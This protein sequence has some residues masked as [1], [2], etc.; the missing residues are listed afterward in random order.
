M[1]KKTTYFCVF[2]F[3]FLLSNYGLCQERKVKIIT[4]VET[5]KNSTGRSKMI[6][7]TSIRNSE[8]FTTTRTEGKDTKQKD[9]NRS[10]AKV[11]NLQETKL[12][13][14]VNAGGVQY[15]NVASNDAIVASRVAELLTE[16]WELKSVVSSM[17]NKSTSFQ[18][19]RYIFIQ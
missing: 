19:T 5:T 7:V 9:I 3:L 4:V 17:E 18:M 13:N 8:D 10:D 11:D 1:L 2:V 12:L 16:G 14:I 6:E 15:R